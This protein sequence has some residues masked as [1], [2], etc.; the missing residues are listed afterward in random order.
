MAAVCG[1][2]SNGDTLLLCEKHQSAVLL[3]LAA[4]RE[5]RTEEELKP[6]IVRA[7]ALQAEVLKCPHCERIVTGEACTP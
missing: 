7:L 6:L 2:Y 5:A 4:R 3:D 1:A